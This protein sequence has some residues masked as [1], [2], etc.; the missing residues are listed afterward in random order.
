ME[1]SPRKTKNRVRNYQY[2][3]DEPEQEP[4]S[5]LRT[6]LSNPSLNPDAMFKFRTTISTNYLPPPDLTQYRATFSSTALPPPLPIYQE[7][8]TPEPMQ[9]IKDHISSLREKLEKAK[10]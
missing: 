1:R 7:R 5:R 9:G 10:L 6:S 8:K 2:V 4:P 3:D